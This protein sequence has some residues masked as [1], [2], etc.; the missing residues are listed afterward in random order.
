MV[1]G[2]RLEDHVVASLRIGRPV[3][4][5]VKGYEDA[6]AVA[7]WKLLL[8]VEDHAVWPPVRRE[9]S[10]R[11]GLARTDA[12]GVAVAAV[13]GREHEF[14]LKRIV[15]TLGPTVVAPWLQK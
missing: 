13:L 15:V 5:P 3:P 6:I 9:G 8:I 10:H 7:G 14:L 12:D 2:Q 1:L 4:G 11:S